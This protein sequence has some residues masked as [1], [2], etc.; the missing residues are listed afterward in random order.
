MKGQGSTGRIFRGFRIFVFLLP[1]ICLAALSCKTK[2]SP[3]P[4]FTWED[5]GPDSTVLNILVQTPQGLLMYGQSVNLALSQDSLNSKLLVRRTP[6]NTM[7]IAV[8][9][10][11]YPRIIYYNCYAVNSVQTFYGSGLVHLLPS[12]RRDT[13]LIVY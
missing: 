7:G 6:T 12:A 4:V 13:V 8:F 2:V 1:F 11:L 3:P 10:K 5:D 9:R